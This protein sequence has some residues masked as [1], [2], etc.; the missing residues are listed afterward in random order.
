MRLF[1]ERLA[2]SVAGLLFLVAAPLAVEAEPTQKSFSIGCL[3]AV[4]AE[5]VAPYRRGLEEGLRDLGYVEGRNIVIHRRY[6]EGKPERLPDLAAELVRLKVDVI[7]ATTNPAISAVRRATASIPI[8]MVIAADPVGT[9]FI[10][11]LGRPG[12]N[13]TG[14]TLDTGL[15]LVGRR[16]ELLKEIA[17][18]VSRVAVLR[19]PSDEGAAQTWNAA[20]DAGRQLGITVRSVEVRTLDDFDGAFGI[21]V[22]ARVDGVLVGAGPLGFTRRR[23]VA[24]LAARWRLP[25]VYPFR[26]SVD[27]G[28]LMSYGPSLIDLWRRS[29]KHV[30]RILRGSK[31]A[32]LPVEQPTRFE[33][34]INMR[35]AKALGI[36]IP[37][38][39]LLRADQI[40]D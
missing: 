20:E 32:D 18:K 2:L 35:T 27:E 8:V 33:L 4:T 15:E 3:M 22:R 30:D 6:A 19:N 39:V 7:V 24:E 12:G 36:T 11:S 38:S 9:G 28:G 34:V 26:E 1:V 40:I 5:A 13:I 10:T 25:A 17:P 29:A 16:L 37:P 21:M 14:V 23:H 31:P